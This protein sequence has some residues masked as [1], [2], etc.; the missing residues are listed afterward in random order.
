MYGIVPHLRHKMLTFENKSARIPSF[1]VPLLALVPEDGGHAK[2]R[3]LEIVLPIQQQVLWLDVPVADP[4]LVQVLQSGDQLVEPPAK[5]SR[6]T[7]LE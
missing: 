2:V 1:Q 6:M 7:F 3:D 4:L 5:K